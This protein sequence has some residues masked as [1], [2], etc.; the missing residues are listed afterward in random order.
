MSEKFRMRG[1]PRKPKRARIPYSVELNDGETLCSILKR[2]KGVDPSTV[3]FKVE[4][5]TD[6]GGYTHT[7]HSFEY[8]TAEAEEVFKERIEKYEKKLKKWEKWYEENEEQIK[9]IESEREEK[10][11]EDAKRREGKI[12]KSLEK[13]LANI[14]KRLKKYK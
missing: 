4:T 1:K 11:R 9:R 8:D 5:E 10:A 6:Y 3:R 14:E 13:E 7:D 2:L 12:K